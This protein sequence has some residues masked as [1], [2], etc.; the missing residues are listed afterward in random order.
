MSAV[1]QQNQP[2]KRCI[3]ITAVQTDGFPCRV[4]TIG[5]IKSQSCLEQDKRTTK[6]WEATMTDVRAKRI[7]L[8]L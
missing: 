8:L 4:R 6:K 3:G 5:V 7:V 1:L 2:G